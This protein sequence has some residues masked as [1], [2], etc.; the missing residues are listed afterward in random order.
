MNNGGYLLTYEWYFEFNETINSN[1]ELKFK[2]RIKQEDNTEFEV[3]TNSIQ[4]E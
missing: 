2:I 3:E 1:E 4:I